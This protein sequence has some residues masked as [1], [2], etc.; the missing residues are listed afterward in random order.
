[1]NKRIIYLFIFILLASFPK[2]APA[3]TDVL[4][5]V[6]STINSTLKEVGEVQNKISGKVREVLSFK[7]SPEQLL[8]AV[9][10][11]ELLAKGEKLKEMGENIKEKADKVKEVAETAKE[12]KEEYMA[13]YQELNAAATEKF[14]QA[15][16]AFNKYKKMYEEYK[17]KAQEYIEMG[18][19]VVEVAGVVGATVGGIVAT[20]KG[21]DGETPENQE[22]TSTP[23][24]TEETSQDTKKT[25]QY[26]PTDISKTDIDAEKVGFTEVPSANKADILSSVSLLTEG[27]IAESQEA[28]QVPDTNILETNEVD[29]SSR[30]IM[31]SIA[32]RKVKP[33]PMGEIAK[34]DV[35]MQD[36]LTNISNKS[37]TV[38]EGELPS[39]GLKES[40]KKQNVR[41]KFGKA[42]AEKIAVEEFG[43]AEKKVNNENV[44]IQNDGAKLKKPATKGFKEKAQADKKALAKDTIAKA[45]AKN[46]INKAD[47]AGK[48]KALVSSTSAKTNKTKTAVTK[49]ID[50]AKVKADIKSQIK[51]QTKELKA[52]EKINAL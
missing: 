1:M 27:S 20:A 35:N 36:Q 26:T 49:T 19:E 10:G 18:K 34:T 8:G 7:V 52:K 39:A 14:A 23:Q 30:D 45:V 29:I 3:N 2:E 44:K 21:K 32:E 22:N 33:R 46:T 15:N 12:K 16:E 48:T 6:L 24:D 5:N 9:G 47:L 28:I 50:A 43:K 4:S 25:P 40:V 41:E 13:K 37:L 42:K 38:E 51:T 31:N 17:T 11:K